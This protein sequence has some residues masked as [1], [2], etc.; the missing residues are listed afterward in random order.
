MPAENITLHA[1][2]SPSVIIEVNRIKV[3]N[4]ILNRDTI[5]IPISKSITIRLVPTIFPSNATYMDI[6][7]ESSNPDIVCVDNNGVLVGKAV[8]NVKITATTLDGNYSAS[9]SVVSDNFII[10]RDF[11]FDA[12]TNTI[13]GYLGTK[14]I[15]DIPSYISDIPVQIIGPKAFY[16]NIYIS[17]VI[18]PSSIKHIF[19]EAFFECINLW[20]IE[21][22]SDVFI[23]HCLL[24]YSE[25]FHDAYGTGGS[26]TYARID[27]SWN[28]I[29]QAISIAGISLDRD[30]LRMPVSDTF[31]QIRAKTLP[32]DATNK[33][34]N[35]VSSKE[36]V[37]GVPSYPGPS[38]ANIKGISEGTTVITAT[39]SDGSFTASCTVTVYI[40]I[41]YE[42]FIFDSQTGTISGYTGNKVNLE[43][44]E[45]INSIPVKAIGYRAFKGN[46]YITS[47]KIPSSITSIE[48][49]A[50]AECEK[51]NIIEIGPDVKISVY[52][53]DECFD[54]YTQ[55]KDSYTV[56]GAGTYIIQDG[57]WTKVNHL[58]SVKGISLDHE[59]VRIPA[60]YSFQSVIIAS[61]QPSDAAI[62]NIIWHIKDPI[63]GY[64][65][66]YY[67]IV[68]SGISK[69]ET[70]LT[71]TTQDGGFEA[72]CKITVYDPIV[73]DDFLFDAL[74][75]TIACYTGTKT[76]I[77]IPDFI[78]GIPVQTIGKRAF[79]WNSNITSMK[80]PSSIKS[81]EQD[82][83]YGCNNLN[84]I[85]IESGI[86]IGYDA[87]NEY[88]SFRDAYSAGGSGIYLLNN[89]DGWIKAK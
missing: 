79:Y 76:T 43:I 53:F 38:I 12:Q 9:C 78:E 14:S 29:N 5:S 67:Y 4:I 68:I 55:F 32:S 57:T 35:W 81:I 69:G 87:F 49:A 27:N 75:G 11:I 77:E 54:N 19:Y 22:E 39:T 44:P 80:I 40:P 16:G 6:I 10:D 88:S 15:L 25:T 33:G 66:S 89:T 21:I 1:T 2:W 50:F 65:N 74:T 56:S 46:T 45:T 13:V 41:I 64:Y 3:T 59:E 52:A 60:Y 71:A 26:G 37:V 8:G 30:K 70:V 18:I 84:T 82:A 23:G 86:S 47:I 58:I 34:I 36:S 17:S 85:E 31:Y 7:W 28:K 61:I 62:R 20:I 48:D 24:N 72:S 63:I 42:D 51:L 73:H 83:F